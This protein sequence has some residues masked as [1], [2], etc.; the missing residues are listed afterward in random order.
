MTQSP[1]SENVY[2]L[3]IKGFLAEAKKYEYKLRANKSWEGYQLP[4]EGNANFV[5]GTTDYPA[6]V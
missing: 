2:T 5:F 3:E 6:G 1:T 4:A